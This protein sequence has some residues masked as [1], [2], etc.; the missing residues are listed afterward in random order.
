MLKRKSHKVASKR[1]LGRNHIHVFTIA[2]FSSIV[3][4]FSAQHNL[5][6]NSVKKNNVLS[7][8]KEGC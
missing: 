6:L 5:L 3:V 1:K 2:L 7:Q 4:H 8:L